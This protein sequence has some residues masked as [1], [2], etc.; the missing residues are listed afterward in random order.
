MKNYILIATFFLSVLY[1]PSLLAEATR[2]TDRE[3]INVQPTGQDYQQAQSQGSSNFGDL[4]SIRRDESAAPSSGGEGSADRAYKARNA[5]QQGNTGTAEAIVAAA[6]LAADA[7]AAFAAGNWGLGAALS[8]MSALETAQ[9][10]ATANTATENDGQDK[11]ITAN[12]SIGS[13]EGRS[14][15]R[16]RNNASPISPELESTLRKQ[17]V[18]VEQF[19]DKM[20]SG[21]FTKVEDVIDAMGMS[22]KVTEYDIKQAERIA[23]KTIRTANNQ[24]E[25]GSAGGGSLTGNESNGLSGSGTGITS[26]TGHTNNASRGGGIDGM[27][28]NNVIE[29]SKLDRSKASEGSGSIALATGGTMSDF[30]KKFA[31]DNK[32]GILDRKLSDYEIQLERANIFPA[33]GRAQIFQIAHRNYREFGK[34]RKNTKLAI[35]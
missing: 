23:D 34:W 24:T 26:R 16:D 33:V 2:V 3:N 17:G 7:G 11:Q 15:I 6:G 31:D 5:K 1:T 9:A 35:R 32:Q 27:S 13:N 29:I 22:G 18:N 14:S 4:N 30:M 21:A 8:A 25:N 28:G 12:E 19:K 10:I 20:S